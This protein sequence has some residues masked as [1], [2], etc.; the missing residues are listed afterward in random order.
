MLI[1]FNFRPEMIISFSLENFLSFGSKNTLSFI[2]TPIKDKADKTFTPPSYQW[3]YRLLRSVGIL[4]Y[5]SAGK[6][7]FLK[8]IAAMKYAVL[9][10]TISSTNVFTSS[11]SPFLLRKENFE[12]TSLEI[13]FFLNNTKYRYGFKILDSLITEEWLYYS[14]PTVRENN[15][16]Y[17][18]GGGITY[19]KNWNKDV[20]NSLEPLF[21]RANGQTL[22]LSILGILNV[23]PAVEIIKWFEKITVIETFDADT[24]I[25]FT[26]ERLQDEIFKLNFLGILREASLGFNTIVESKA[27]QPAQNK[28]SSDFMDFMVQNELMPKVKYVVHTVHKMFDNEGKEAGTIRFDLRQQESAGTKKFFGLIGLL[29]DSML[30]GS[31]LLFDELDAQFHFAMYETLVIFFNNAK[32]NPKGA[33]LIF[34]SHNTTL[35]KKSKIRRDQ[36]YTIIKNTKSESELRRIHEKG[37]A[38]RT[39]QSIEKEYTEGKLKTHPDIDFNLFTGILDFPDY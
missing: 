33:Q 9:Y 27:A 34:T 30:K 10:S 6:S 13:L 12:P 14:E 4:G 32:I 38:V 16:F 11:I 22:F 37:N 5:N 3:D 29:L 23:R 1:S 19:N 26:S 2:A 17:R 28:L 25:D 20:D 18:Q 8:A 36:L 24:F 39:D 31:I 15:L 35:L 21:K 7:N